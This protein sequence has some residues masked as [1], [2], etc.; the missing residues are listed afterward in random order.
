MPSRGRPAPAAAWVFLPA[1]GALVAHA[2]VLILDLAPG[3][4]RPL[5]GGRTLRGRR[6]L[7]DNKTVRGAI[8][9]FGGAA[10]SALA[11]SRAPWFRTRLPE[12]VREAPAPLYAGLLGAAVVLAELPTSFVKRQIGIAP[13]QRRR[14]AA[15]A[16]MSLY[17][18]GDFVLAGA[19]ILRPVWRPKPGELAGAFA[20]VSAAH[21]GVSVVGYAIGARDSVL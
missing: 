14:S 10:V 17:D 16:L 3:L 19:L 2:P 6:L 12:R 1:A 9:M 15:G 20:V 5:D 4:S 8:V 7:G 21:L 13:G 18:Q 11:L